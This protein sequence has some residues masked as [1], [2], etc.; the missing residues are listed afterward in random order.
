MLLCTQKCAIWHSTPKNDQAPDVISA[1]AEKPRGRDSG[2]PGCLRLFVHSVCSSVP[3]QGTPWTFTSTGSLQL[4]ISLFLCVML[5]PPYWYPQSAGREILHS[6]LR[7]LCPLLHK[8]LLLKALTSRMK[9]TAEL[10]KGKRL[11]C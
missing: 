4:W 5:L 3:R 1:R 6:S 2:F 9:R 11:I 7:S 10:S 8:G